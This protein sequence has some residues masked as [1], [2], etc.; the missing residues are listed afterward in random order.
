MLEAYFDESGIHSQAKVCVVAGFYGRQPSWR[1]FERQWNNVLSKYPELKDKGFHAKVFFARANGIRVGPYRDWSDD[2]AQQFLNHLLKCIND[3]WISPVGFGVVVSD[4]L[5]LPL[6]I[7]Q[8]LTGAKFLPSGEYVSSGCPQK[9]YYVPFHFCVMGAGKLSSASQDDK[10]HFFAGLDRTFAGYASELLKNSLDDP[11]L[12]LT[13]RSRLGSISY[14]LSKDTPGIQAADLLAYRMYKHSLDLLKDTET[15]TPALLTRLCKRAKKNQRF[16]LFTTEMFRLM[17][18]Q[19]Q[20]EYDR[21]GV[22]AK[23]V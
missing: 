22:L 19:A 8:W 5:R 9:S 12:P 17:R 4:F 10:I 11:R 1:R 13:L 16:T 21:I 18:E 3:N 23:G 14:P 7:R 6:T 20:K 2:K 15:P